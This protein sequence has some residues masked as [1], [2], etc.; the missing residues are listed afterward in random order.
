MKKFIAASLLAAVAQADFWQV[1]KS[2]PASNR[3]YDS[4]YTLFDQNWGWSNFEYRL[5]LEWDTPYKA[6]NGP[7]FQLD[8]SDTPIY[9]SLTG[10]HH[11]EEYS[12]QIEGAFDMYLNLAFGSDM[13]S[14]NEYWMYMLHPQ[15]NLF[16]L[17]P[18][19]QTIWWTNFIGEAIQNGAMSGDVNVGGYY[20][21]Q[22][23]QALIKHCQTA[24]YTWGD[25]L[26]ALSYS[27]PYYNN[28]GGSDNYAGGNYNEAINCWDD[29]NHNYNVI[30]YLP[31]NI[32]SWAGANVIYEE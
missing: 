30:D 5:S 14:T 3:W 4:G 8:N 20:S 11:Y 15:I 18:Y 21:L 27:D 1:P 2:M 9:A 23:G 25:L 12:V 29:A 6:G 13:A 28:F 10:D 31:A 16:K 22:F 19:A 26:G 17:K 32:Q 24:H 7:H